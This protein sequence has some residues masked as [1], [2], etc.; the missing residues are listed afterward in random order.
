[1]DSMY[2]GDTL[3]VDLEAGTTEQVVATEIDEVGPGLAAG[4]A[5]YEKYKDSD[6]LVFGSGLFTGT[7]V[8]AACLGFVL[9]TSPLTGEPA[10]APLSLYAGSEMKLSGFSMV[11]IKGVS[12]KPVYLWLH[13]GVPDIADASSLAGMDTW[14]TTDAIRREMGESMIQVISIGPAGEASSRLASFSI[15]YWGSGD[16]AALGAV[17]GKKNLKAVAL[18]GLGM[19]DAEDPAEFYSRSL[20]LFEDAPREKGFAAIC[21]RIGAGDL[22][23]WLAPLTHRVRSCFACPCACSTFVKYNEDPTVL[24]SSDVDE[25]GMLITSPA[26]ALWLMEGGWEAEPAC[27]AMEAM[28]REGVDMVRG[29]RELSA[30]PLGDAGDI[31]AAVK[32]LEGSAEAGWPVGAPSPYGLFGAWMPPLGE[33]ESWRLANMAGYLLGICPT[34]LMLS[35]VDLDALG[36]LCQPAAGMELEMDPDLIAGLFG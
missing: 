31:E 10:V 8:P 29:A 9:G 26:A 33:A 11:L 16:T 12:A 27:R 23:A 2:Y 1:M 15:N 17:M 35:G 34:Y 6:P 20:A 7:P 14:Q 13:D 22:D 19:L 3:I 32:A 36:G 4:L 18:R 30:K 21:G 28:A 5:L 25:P 24:E